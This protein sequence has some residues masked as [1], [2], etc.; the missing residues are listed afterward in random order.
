MTGSAL[1]TSVLVAVVLATF[2]L[3]KDANAQR[4]RR[5][6]TPAGSSAPN[7]TNATN[8]TNPTSGAA[9]NPEAEAHFRRGLQLAT[10]HSEMPALVEFR[11]AYELSRNELIRF[12]IAAVEIELNQYAE[13]LASL[14]AYER[15]APPDVVRA[16]RAQIDALRDRILSRSGIVRVPLEVQGLRVQCEAIAADARIVREG[17]VAR[18]GIR[19][20]VGRYRVSVSAPG[21]RSVE[22]EF[23][24]A[25]G[26]MITLDQPLEALETTVTVRANVDDAEVRVDGRLIGRTPLS[27]IP[28]SEGTHRIEGV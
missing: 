14:E 16:R 17:A 28:V 12:N 20:P 22:R 24:V 6:S 25:S 27:P 11:R 10:E 4:R 2:S 5:R 9:A 3:A 15:N 26:A 7:A 1:R 23:D 21:H 8:A 13:G 18:A 19:I